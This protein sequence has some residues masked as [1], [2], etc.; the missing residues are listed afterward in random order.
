M[1][2]QGQ[3]LFIEGGSGG[4]VVDNNGTFGCNFMRV[5]DPS[6]WDLQFLDGIVFNENYILSVLSQDCESYE[7]EGQGSDDGQG[8]WNQAKDGRTSCDDDGGGDALPM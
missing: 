2:K 4:L 1:Q 7:S 3:P 5:M 8:R 6:A